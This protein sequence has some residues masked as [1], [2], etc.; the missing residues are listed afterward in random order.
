[1]ERPAVRDVVI[2]SEGPWG[3][4]AHEVGR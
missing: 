1:L 4:G 2:P 3:P